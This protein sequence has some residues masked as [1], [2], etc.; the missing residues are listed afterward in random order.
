MPG[1]PI[2]PTPDGD[3]NKKPGTPVSVWDAPGFVGSNYLP[4]W[5]LGQKNTNGTNL[6]SKDY[7]TWLYQTASQAW[8][9]AAVGA[10]GPQF[11]ADLWY[12]NRTGMSLERFWNQ[13]RMKYP[14]IDE[15]INGAMGG[16]GGGRGSYGG[17][18]GGTSRADQIAAAVAAIRNQAETIGLALDDNMILDLAK[19]TVSENWTGDQLTDALL[20]DMTKATKPGTYQATMTAIREQAKRQ[21]INVSDSTAQDWARRILSGEMAVETVNTIFGQQA[22]AEWGWATEALK[23]GATMSDILAP[24]RDTIASELE[25]GA[26]TVNLMDDRWRKMVTREDV[27]GAAR[28]ATMTE[29]LQAARKD[30]A[31]ANTAGAARRAASTAAMLRQMFEGN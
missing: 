3:R 14:G 27:K 18:G 11:Q 29:V 23:T 16:G 9:Q 13:A 12:A 8:F 21:L 31:Y 10:F 30:Q 15:I 26:D 24:A 1:A 7:N 22:A 4:G 2:A 25:L 17:G 6:T 28:A 5:H 20:G 19:K